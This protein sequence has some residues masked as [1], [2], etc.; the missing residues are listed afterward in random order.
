MFRGAAALFRELA[1]P[2]PMA[3]TM[4]EHGEWLAGA[5]AAPLLVGAAEA[6]GELGARPWIERLDRSPGAAVTA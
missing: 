4:L 5:A 1:M 6:C 3:V 2:F